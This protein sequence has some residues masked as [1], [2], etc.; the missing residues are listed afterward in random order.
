MVPILV[1][2][3]V[4][5]LLT[6]THLDW[7]ILQGLASV[8]APFHLATLCLSARKYPT[9]ATSY[10]ICQNLRLYL[11][12]EVS[13]SSL[14]TALKRVLLEKFIY[15]FDSKLTSDQKNLK[16]VSRNKMKF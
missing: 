6:F 10:W 8:L 12:N 15:H 11:S 4:D 7:E 1:G 14:E 2:R 13:D 5:S 9:L 3:F 16:L